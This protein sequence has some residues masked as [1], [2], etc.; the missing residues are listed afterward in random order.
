V[1]VKA[2]DNKGKTVVVS[3]AVRELVKLGDWRG[4]AKR[5]DL[6]DPT[7]DGLKSVVVVQAPRGGPVAAVSR[8]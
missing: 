3:N 8:Y 2:G 4:K 6:P 7:A 5:F 1:K